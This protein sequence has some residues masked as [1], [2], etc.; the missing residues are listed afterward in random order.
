[1]SNSLTGPVW[2]VDT[3]G[4]LTAGQITV[5]SFLWTCVNTTSN[6]ARVQV[7]D[8]AGH[9]VFQ[10]ACGQAITYS[11]PLDLTGLIATYVAQGTLLIQIG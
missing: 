6:A 11:E 8:T 4:I 9:V 3:P 2:S 5:Y 10:N 1:M 7:T